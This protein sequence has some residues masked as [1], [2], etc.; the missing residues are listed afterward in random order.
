ML[1]PTRRRQ[2]DYRGLPKTQRR[3]QTDCRGIAE[4]AKAEAERLQGIAET[5][6]DT[7]RDERDE[8]ERLQGIAEDA[9][10]EAERL[11]GL[12]ETA[13]TK[14]ETDKAEA[15]RLRGIAEDAKTEA[16]RLRGIAELAK[17]EADRLRVLAETERDNALK[18]LEAANKEI[19]RLDRFI[20]PT[21]ANW[22]LAVNPET[23]PNVI[24]PQN[25]F[26]QAD[27]DSI[28]TEEQPAVPNDVQTLNLLTA[29]FDGLPLD[30]EAADGVAFFQGQINGT[31]YNYAGVF[32]GTDFGCADNR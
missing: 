28:S 16:D 1:K 24:S 27:A 26:L 29:T 30:W 7:A 15:D 22:K 21:Y 25:Q 8:A 5:D 31:N 11:K 23:V 10:A 9:K 12:A 17:T 14:A 4:T 18:D 3:R 19:T 2:N 32:S 13:K 20:R 6:R